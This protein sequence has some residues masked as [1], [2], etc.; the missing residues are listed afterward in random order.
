[1]GELPKPDA[2]TGNEGDRRLNALGAWLTNV[3]PQ[4]M[5][6]FAPASVDASFRRYFRVWLA[7][8]IVVPA[9]SEPA[10][11]LIAMDAPPSREDC[12]PFVAVAKLLHAAGV[13]AP[14]VL[15]MNLEQGFLL[16]TDLGTRTYLDS[17]DEVTAPA[18]YAD[19]SAALVRWQLASR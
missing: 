9:Q 12:R 15:A 11:T 13:H 2:A 1:M 19:A 17:L 5:T 16:L 14:L 8:S 3:L 4:P 7:D 10:C 6:A 18:L